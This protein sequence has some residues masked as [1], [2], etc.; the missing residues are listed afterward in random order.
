MK[1][2]EVCVHERHAVLTACVLDV[3]AARRPARLSDECDAVLAC[4]VDVIAKGN[5]PVAHKRYAADLPD[6]FSSVVVVEGIKR[7]VEHVA[8]G[9]LLKACEIAFNISDPPVDAVLLLHAVL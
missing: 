6:P 1:Q 2:T 7:R 4:A 8:Q 9:L 5:E 3:L